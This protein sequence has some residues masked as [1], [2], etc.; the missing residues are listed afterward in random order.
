MAVIVI[1][2]R[3]TSDDIFESLGADCVDVLIPTEGG[4]EDFTVDEFGG[5]G[6]VVGEASG[7]AHS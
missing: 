3:P 7:E 2:F 6:H 5:G 1:R 4:R